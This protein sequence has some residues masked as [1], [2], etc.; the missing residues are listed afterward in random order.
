[1]SIEPP[2]YT[3]T[4]NVVFAMMPKMGDAELRVVLAVCRKTF[5]WHKSHDRISISQIEEDTGL[6]RQGVIDGTRKA[7]ERGVLKRRKIKGSQQ[8]DYEID[9]AEEPEQVNSA[10]QASRLVVESVPGSASQAGGLG[11]VKQLDQFGV[12]LVK[13]VDTQKKV[14]N[15]ERKKTECSA[16]KNANSA[17]AL[18]PSGAPAFAEPAKAETKELASKPR[19]EFF[20]RLAQMTGRLPTLHGPF[21]G[22]TKKQL[23]AIGAT[24]ADLCDFQEYW[25]KCDWRG[26]RGD[27]PDLPQVTGSWGR[28]LAWR[29]AG[30][31][32]PVVAKRYDAATARNDG[33]AVYQGEEAAAR[34]E[35]EER[36]K[37]PDYDTIPF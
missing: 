14:L 1:M 5:G 12:Q 25:T 13:P 19:D 34:H 33:F 11:L 27:K 9:C 28:M 32:L 20:D 26:Q 31:P 30:K 35:A 18:A 16:P 15:K 3:Q 23:T 17:E 36:A 10:S 37:N 22:R 7:I 24:V 4:P 8:F 6:S 2:N 29:E 21:I